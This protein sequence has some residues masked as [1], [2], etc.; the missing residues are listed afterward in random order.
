MLIDSINVFDDAIKGTTSTWYTSADLNERL[1]EAD[2]GMFHAVTTQVVGTPSLTVRVEHSGDSENWAAM[3][4]DPI[5]NNAA[6]DESLPQEN[7]LVSTT[8]QGRSRYVRLKITLTGTGT[9]GC[10]LKLYAALRSQGVG[11][12]G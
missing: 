7:S 2:F 8:Y 5:I 10:R 1:G 12:N 6:V 3:P 4:G 11:V 9:P